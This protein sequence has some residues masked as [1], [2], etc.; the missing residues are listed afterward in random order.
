LP[1]SDGDAVT[2][3]IASLKTICDGDCRT[4]TARRSFE[5]LL[6][7]FGRTDRVEHIIGSFKAIS[8]E[9]DFKITNL[10][11]ISASP[12]PVRL[13]SAVIDTQLSRRPTDC[14][15]ADDIIELN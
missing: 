15:T 10:M 6:L 12:A 2:H 3:V 8:I 5:R 11:G 1:L 4:A 7:P 13:V 9:G 14:R